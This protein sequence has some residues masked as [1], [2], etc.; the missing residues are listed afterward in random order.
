MNRSIKALA[1]AAFAL[2]AALGATSAQ[3]SAN[4][5]T[6]NLK[7]KNADAGPTVNM[8]RTSSLPTGLSG[9]SNPAAIIT[10]GNFDPGSGSAT[11]SDALPAL[12]A[13]IHIDVTFAQS[14]DGISNACTFTI[15]V[16]HDSNITQPYQVQFSNNGMARCVVPAAARSST[17]TFPGTFE[18]DWST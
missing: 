18:L 5:F 1:L 14:S 13:S 8:K 12:N 15:T 3:A 4:N 11:F 17:G 7:F 10:P 16:A 2:A 9:M 6:V